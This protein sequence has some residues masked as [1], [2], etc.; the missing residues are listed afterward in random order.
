[1]NTCPFFGICGGC[2]YDFTS[3]DYHAQKI[4]ELDGLPITGNA[5]WID[6]GTRRRADFAFADGVFG[7]YRH[8]S[9]NIVPV[10]HCPLCCAAI[11]DILPAVA[12]LPW[13]GAGAVCRCWGW[14]VVEF[15]G[16]HRY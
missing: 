13:G 11:N 7:F 15:G 16:W 3:P 2:K 6:A 8:R 4:S 12:S 14:C 10:Q 1:M 9:K 5:I